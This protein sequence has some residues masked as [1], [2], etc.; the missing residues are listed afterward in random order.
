MSNFVLHRLQEYIQQ[1]K[2]RE[3]T[4]KL[5]SSPKSEDLRIVPNYVQN[6]TGEVKI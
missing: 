5:S 2:R 3:K 1:E 4:T 6:E